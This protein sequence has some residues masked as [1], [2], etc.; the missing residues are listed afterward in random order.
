MSNNSTDRLHSW[1]TQDLMAEIRCI[2][3]PRYKRSL[4]DVEVNDIAENL[5]GVV[6]VMLKWKGK[7]YEQRIV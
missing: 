7:D 1:L 4:S 5:S 2:Y 6:E 3:E